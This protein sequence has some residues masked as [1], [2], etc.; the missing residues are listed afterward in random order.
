MKASEIKKYANKGYQ[1]ESLIISKQD[2][3]RVITGKY[4]DSNLINSRIILAS[5]LYD[6]IK[7]KEGIP[8]NT[9]HSVAQIL[10]L[11]STYIQGFGV[12][13]DLIF[14][15][16]YTK[17]SAL[18]K[19][20][21]EILA[22]INEIK[23]NKAK[24]G[25]TPN[26]KFAPKGSQRIYGKLNKISHPSN[27]NIISGLLRHYNDGAINGVNVIPKFDKSYSLELYKSHL[28][29]AFEITKESILIL[30]EL[31][32]DKIIEKLN[33]IKVFHY[34]KYVKEKL[35]SSE[36]ITTK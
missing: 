36:V 4:L 18:I 21:Y 10:H 19:Q 13:E 26:V 30:T 28:Y 1:L 6:I 2:S 35:I 17:A 22:R 14:A 23:K 8:G 20:E 32:G 5:I 31:Y 27:P 15:G 12:T 3:I 34:F 11:I 25:E 16:Q 24:I 9:N 29:I 7:V 33:R